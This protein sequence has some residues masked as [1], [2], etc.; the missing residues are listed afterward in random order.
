M[1]GIVDTSSLVAIARYYLS[2]KDGERLLR[3]LEAKFESRELI[4]LS[5]IH[6]EAS[7]VQG[8]IAISKMEF[9]NN[10]DW[11]IKDDDLLPP[12]PKKFSNQMDNNVCVTK[13]KERLS[14]EAYAIQ[15]EVYMRTGDARMLLYALNN[16][17]LSPC[18]IT[19]E[20][21]YVNDGKLFKKLPAICEIINVKYMS[22]TEWLSLNHAE[23]DWTIPGIG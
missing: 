20:T 8:G 6:K 5:S 7:L 16:M 12:A 23:I 4:L 10:Q 21:R 15:K 3:F 1:I 18:I 17:D 14:A 13:M 9:L 22:I 19:E 2:I 11:R